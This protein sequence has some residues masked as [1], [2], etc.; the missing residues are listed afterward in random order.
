MRRVTIA[1]AILMNARGVSEEDAYK[2]IGDQAISKRT[3][4]EEIADAVINANEILGID[5]KK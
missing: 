1:K 5:V 4:A 2:I 3:T